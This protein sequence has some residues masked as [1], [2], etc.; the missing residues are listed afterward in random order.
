[1]EITVNPRVFAQIPSL[2][3]GALTLSNVNNQIDITPFFETEYAQ[4]EKSIIAKFGGTELGQYPLIA[5]WREIYKSFG[6]KK[7]RSSIESLIR[8]VSGGKGLYRINPLVDLYNLASLKFELPCGGE[9]TNKMPAPLEL[10]IADGTEEFLQLGATE[11]EHPIKGE[12]I[13]KSG[14]IVVCRNINYRES[15]LTKLTE[16]TTNAIIVFEDA[17]G[18]QLSPALDYLALHAQSLLG[19]KITSRKVIKEK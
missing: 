2:S 19:A 15:D 11:T 5:R 4:I 9:D 8:R 12:I 18:A 13:Y 10:T 14:P 7:A 1:M 6:E 3:V 16:S 17:L